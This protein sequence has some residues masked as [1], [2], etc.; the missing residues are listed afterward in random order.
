MIRVTSRA[1]TLLALVM[2]VASRTHA[3]QPSAPGLMPE[4]RADVILGNQPAVQIG[5]GVQLPFGYYVRLGIDGAA[6][7]RID[8]AASRAA[9]SSR[10][11]GRV[12]VLVRFL[13]D[14]FRQAKYGLS[15]GGGMSVRAEAG[16]RARPLLLVAADLEGRRAANGWVPALQVGLGGGVRLGVVLRRGAVGGR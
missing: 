6:G 11:D 2:L 3:Q 1:G 8:D 7:L 9:S 13:L 4:L 15:L 16:D 12:D 10:V 14:P 5:G